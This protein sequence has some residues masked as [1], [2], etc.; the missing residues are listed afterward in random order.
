MNLKMNKFGTIL[1]SAL[2]ALILEQPASGAELSDAAKVEYF[3]NKIYPILKENCFKCH[4][5][6]ERIKGEFRLT[7]RDGV[8][9]G[10]ESGAAINLNKPEESLFL[11]MLSWKDENH[12]MPPDEKL[13]DAQIAL[14]TE[15]VKMGAPYNPAK[16]IHGK[17]PFREF[18]SRDCMGHPSSPIRSVGRSARPAIFRRAA[19][20]GFHPSKT[21]SSKTDSP[22]ACSG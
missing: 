6:R 15:W 19:S 8:L 5:G 12:E 4:G 20:R 1:F 16:E 9:R 14:L 22:L 18:P 21:T 13:P 11:T 7:N 3:D 2:G 10:G 17:D